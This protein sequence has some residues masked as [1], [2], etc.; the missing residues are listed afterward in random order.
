MFPFKF[1]TNPGL[2]TTFIEVLYPTEYEPALTENQSTAKL[3]VPLDP[4]TDMTSELSLLKV[5]DPTIEEV[6]P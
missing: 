6:T 4:I 2:R 1:V 5:M 3:Y